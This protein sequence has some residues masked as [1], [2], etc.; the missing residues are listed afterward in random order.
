MN[1]GLLATHLFDESIEEPQPLTLCEKMDLRNDGLKQMLKCPLEHQAYCAASRCLPDKH[2]LV[3]W[4][5]EPEEAITGG[6]TLAIE[7]NNWILLFKTVTT[8][9]LRYMTK[10]TV[11]S[12]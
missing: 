5:H 7:S 8:H 9:L 3:T 4:Q 1:Q 6:R 10:Q 2:T 12:L 11:T